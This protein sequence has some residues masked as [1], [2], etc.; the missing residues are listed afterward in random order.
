MAKTVNMGM[1][2]TGTQM[3]PLDTKRLLDY[4]KKHPADIK[5]N[6]T[7]LTKE[8]T[9]MTSVNNVLGTIPLPGSAKGAIKT[10]VD[11]LL[12]NQPELLI[13]KLGERLAYERGGVRLYEAAIAKATAFKQPKLVKELKHIRDEEE[14]HMFL[15]IDTLKQL[16]ADPTVMTPS[17]DVVGV[18][19][20]GPMQVLTD[21]RTNIAH[22][23]NALLTLELT[24]NAAWELLI[25][26]L[27]DSNKADVAKKFQKAFLQ[28]QEHLRIIKTFYKKLLN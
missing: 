28:E 3:S 4:V 12:G 25:D 14:E 11:K 20:Q 26:L 19:A 21:P 24:D 16:G 23:L 18:I 9:N 22:C 13:D 27:K 17:A 10:G 15:L 5:G 2:H 7:A 6:E 8:R 1:N